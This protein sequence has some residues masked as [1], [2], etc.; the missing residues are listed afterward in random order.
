[1]SAFWSFFS[2]SPMML[3]IVT[4]LAVAVSIVL[5]FM[6]V[7]T[8]S[9]NKNAEQKSAAMTMDSM[10]SASPTLYE[11]SGAGG[12]EDVLP[13]FEAA[14]TAFGEVEI[15]QLIGEPRVL[16]AAE[17]VYGGATSVVMN[18][19]M[20]QTELF[21]KEQPSVSDLASQIDQS[22]A[23]EP[24][25]SPA[26]D[27]VRY[28]DDRQVY[29]GG[30]PQPLGEVEYSQFN[31]QIYAPI[32]SLPKQLEEVFVD[33]AWQSQQQVYPKAPPMPMQNARQVDQPILNEM[34]AQYV[35][36]QQLQQQS[37]L[38][39]TQQ[40]MPQYFNAPVQIG[41]EELIEQGQLAQSQYIIMPEPSMQ[42]MYIQLPQPQPQL[43]PQ[44]Q[45]Q[46][47]QPMQQ[48]PIIFQ[49]I[50]MPQPVPPQQPAQFNPANNN[51]SQQPF[52]PYPPY[53]Q[54]PPYPHYAPYL[55]YPP[56]SLSPQAAPITLPPPA[57]PHN[58]ASNLSESNIRPIAV[59]EKAAQTVP[60]PHTVPFEY[61]TSP[62]PMQTASYDQ[63]MHQSRE[64]GKTKDNQE[65][66]APPL[67][68][69]NETNRPNYF[70]ENFY[71]EMPKSIVES[72]F[73]GL[74]A[75][76][77]T[78]NVNSITNTAVNAA[79]AITHTP[80]S[81]PTYDNATKHSENSL[82]A[83]LYAALGD[84]HQ[85]QRLLAS[86]QDGGTD[87]NYL[88]QPLF[89]GAYPKIEENPI[90]QHIIWQQER[91]IEQM[92]SIN[93]NYSNAI[94]TTPNTAASTSI[95]NDSWLKAPIMDETRQQEPVYDADDRYA[96]GF[97][98]SRMEIAD[99]TR[100]A[101]I[102]GVEVIERYDK[103]AAPTSLKINGKTYAMLHGTDMGISMTV[104]I[105]DAYAHELCKRH[106]RVMTAKFPKGL[107]WYHV[108]IDESFE[109]KE[110]VY[111][112]LNN[113][114]QY[115]ANM[116]I[117]AAPK[118]TKVNTIKAKSDSVGGNSGGA[119]KGRVGGNG[120]LP[121]SNYPRPGKK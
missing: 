91:Q 110:A 61:R 99:E 29:A 83:S 55:N 26:F 10:G 58:L 48:Q 103:P 75:P 63:P 60:K 69:Q 37:Q 4:G 59:Q 1:M 50:I 41:V 82:L 54:H 84:E 114:M 18:V 98:L 67:L 112:I 2:A 22:V 31:Q 120:V 85:L 53:P 5:I 20:G 78:D 97:S 52:S 107:N 92:A 32:P 65:L 118:V 79:Q 76:K 39:Q 33:P 28:F 46:L 11:P 66:K 64:Y 38:Q 70:S 51:M 80:M 14:P 115:I 27:E 87:G 74:K 62:Q 45:P 49:P 56:Q 73:V 12:I 44:P 116:P 35:P 104:K 24:I 81:H 21:E 68:K 102:P 106:G 72:Y 94:N 25:I 13:I 40:Q 7:Q 95:I 57:A 96:M 101:N 30:T 113:A 89:D 93:H 9:S 109:N 42:P 121:R 47:Q 119:F 105:P 100:R 88:S 77:N 6:I 3:L 111:R 19:P 16:S 86:V 71:K 108:S 17:N 90:R 8:I 15:G 34:M 36:L 117:S 43:Q 23:Y